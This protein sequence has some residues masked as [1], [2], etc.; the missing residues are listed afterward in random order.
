MTK[1]IFWYLSPSEFAIDMCGLD[2]YLLMVMKPHETHAIFFES[3]KKKNKTKYVNT[4]IDSL[5]TSVIRIF[6]IFG[7][8]GIFSMHSVYLC[9]ER[10][11]FIETLYSM[12]V[13][14]SAYS[15]QIKLN[16]SDNW[17][18]HFCYFSDWHSLILENSSSFA[19]S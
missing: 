3:N 12:L 11:I 7:I 19:W 1:W 14:V 9:C 4:W 10:I 17:T 2:Y 13:H 8:F 16:L 15:G 6:G 18:W 5:F